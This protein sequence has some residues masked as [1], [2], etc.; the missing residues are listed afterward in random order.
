[1]E[2]ESFPSSAASSLE[3]PTEKAEPA[4][5]STAAPTESFAEL[6][7]EFEHEHKK[8]GGAQQLEGAVVSVSADSVFLDIGFKVEGVLPRTAF[9]NNADEV[10][11]GDRFPVSVKGRNE[12]HD[13]SAIGDKL[14]VAGDDRQDQKTEDQPEV[15]ADDPPDIGGGRAAPPAWVTNSG[16]NRAR[17]H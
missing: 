14:P 2:N 5:E 16:G 12:E 4:A 8:Q 15:R 13:K 3:N 6:L 17:E 11:A 1:M 10:K 9:E 7:S